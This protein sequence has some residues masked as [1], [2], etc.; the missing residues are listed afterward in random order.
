MVFADREDR[1]A[2]TTGWRTMT[3]RITRSSVT[4]LH[5]FVLRDMDGVQPPGTYL[6]E[7]VEEPLETL[8]FLAYRRVATTITL[9]AIGVVSRRRQVLSID[10]DELQAALARDTSATTA[11]DGEPRRS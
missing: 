2:R 5:D 11:G 3:E 7:T 1:E 10:P 6:I 9:P 4:F 8:S